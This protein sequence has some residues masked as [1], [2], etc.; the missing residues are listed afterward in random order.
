VPR[1]GVDTVIRAMPAILRKFPELHYLVAGEGP[2]IDR[3][4][5]LRG[6]V[7]V[8]N[9]VR[10]IGRLKQSEVAAFHHAIDAFVMPARQE[11]PSVEGFGLV[12]REAN[13][14]G[15]PVVAG[16]SGGVPD[17]V[18]DGETGLLVP[19]N[20]ADAVATA[21]IQLLSDPEKARALGAAGRALIANE[22]TWR[23]T[24]DRVLSACNTLI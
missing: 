15:R 23:H 9:R 17:A 7:G 22:G 13:A 6:Q 14:C 18:R 21:V 5:Q 4:T 19:P 12:F 11:G 8:T 24:A 20:A 10:F 1:K 3:L 2:D 16:L